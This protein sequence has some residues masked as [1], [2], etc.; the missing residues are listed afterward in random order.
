MYWSHKSLYPRNQPKLGSLRRLTDNSAVNA[1]RNVR[2]T[3][4]WNFTKFYLLLRYRIT[5]W[6]RIQSGEHPHEAKINPNRKG[7]RKWLSESSMGLLRYLWLK[8]SRASTPPPLALSFKKGFCTTINFYE[9]L[10]VQGFDP[11]RDI[12]LRCPRS[13]HVTWLAIFQTGPN[14][15]SG[16]PSALS[17]V[18]THNSLFT[19]HPIL[20]MFH[21]RL[22][23]PLFCI[24][25]D[26]NTRAL[27]NKINQHTCGLWWR[28]KFDGSNREKS[29][30]S[31]RHNFSPQYQYHVR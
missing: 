17:L 15:R 1:T 16:L 25:H 23:L 8:Q 10:C 12:S 22:M 28:L 2:F 13:D 19:Y 6:S 9:Q 7:N 29:H 3:N 31:S 30:E 11:S 18:C 26:N 24:Y 21:V 20:R 14:P 5:C 4:Q 27:K